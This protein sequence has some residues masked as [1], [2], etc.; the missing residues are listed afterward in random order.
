MIKKIKEIFYITS[1]IIFF[2][3]I[4]LFYI[5]ENNINHTSKSRAFYEFN[6]NT[7][8]IDDLPL[9]KNDTK[10]IVEVSDDLENYKKEK[11]KYLF[12]KLLEN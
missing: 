11:K 3:F 7:N 9:L 2:I 4:A 6:L 10:N 8:V 5:S 1:F 12:F